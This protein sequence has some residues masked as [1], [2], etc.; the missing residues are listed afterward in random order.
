MVFTFSDKSPIDNPKDWLTELFFMQRAPKSI[1]FGMNSK[2]DD[3]LKQ[4]FSD[5]A[6]PLFSVPDFCWLVNKLDVAKILTA[7]EQSNDATNIAFLVE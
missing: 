4:I 7:N 2:K 6:H 5:N 3:L 1:N